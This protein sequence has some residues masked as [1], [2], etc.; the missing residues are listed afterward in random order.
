MS[1][2][3]DSY[4]LAETPDVYGAYPRLSEQQI[5]ALAGLGSRRRV[6]E[7]TLL[8]RQ[9]DR[10]CDFFVI[11]EGLVAILEGPDR[12]IGVHG[13]GRFLGELNLLTG[14]V[15]FVTAE[16]RQAAE[17]LDVPL[18]P[19]RSLVAED[20]VLGDLILRAYVMRRAI[21]IGLG[22]GFKLIGSRFSPDTRRLREFAARNRLPHTWIDLE[23]D[24]GAESL[25][26]QL[27]IEPGDTPVVIWG[28]EEVLRNPTNAE[29]ARVIG[30]Y[31]APSTQRRWDLV[32]V[33]AGPPGWPPRSTGRP[34]GWLPSP[35]TPSRLAARPGRR[36]ASKTT[37]AFLPGSRAAN[38]L[39][40]PSFRPR[41]S[42]PR[43]MCRIPQCG[44]RSRMAITWSSS[45][46]DPP[47]EPHGPDRRRCPLPQTRGDPPGT[48]RR[49]QRVLRGHA[50]RGQPVPRRPGC[51]RRRR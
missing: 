45:M 20:T 49:D 34:R 40:G 22:S 11:L 2:T 10:R 9:G 43:S 38:W 35:S 33:G 24:A 25:L 21:L 50:A 3:A 26:R 8:Y 14:E 51:R 1:V 17:V 4:P 15:A 48:L 12:L 16:V 28:G 46:T 31:V 47:V 32:V 44:W 36:P 23:S 30:L 41:S 27:G 29:L 19:L 18:E 39:T 7:G 37:W 5:E 13:R 42:G 6:E